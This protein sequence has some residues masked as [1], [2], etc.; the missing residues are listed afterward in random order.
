MIH[1]H[2]ALFISLRQIKI[3]VYI[4]LLIKSVAGPRAEVPREGQPFQL[5]LRLSAP[6]TQSLESAGP[7]T[8]TPALNSLRFSI[9]KPSPA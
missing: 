9:D 1:V 5:V 7:A 2:T 3:F 8:A 6:P 4:L